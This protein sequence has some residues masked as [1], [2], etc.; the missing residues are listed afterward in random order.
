MHKSLWKLFATLSIFHPTNACCNFSG[1]IKNDF[2]IRLGAAAAAAA[3]AL[4]LSN[5]TFRPR[6]HH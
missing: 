6:E 3:A 5:I 2:K 4:M 1:G